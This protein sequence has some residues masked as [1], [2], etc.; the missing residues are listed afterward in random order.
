MGHIELEAHSGSSSSQAEIPTIYHDNAFVIDTSVPSHIARSWFNEGGTLGLLQSEALQVIWQ[1]C[2]QN[3]G[4]D[5]SLGIIS[6]LPRK[7]SQRRIQGLTQGHTSGPM[8]HGCMCGS[9]LDSDPGC[10]TS[11]LLCLQVARQQQGLVDLYYAP[12]YI[13][14]AQ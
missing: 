8:S 5:E 2:V 6:N 12:D 10:L 9:N 1:T 14:V 11:E 7:V 13:I 3:S 4:K